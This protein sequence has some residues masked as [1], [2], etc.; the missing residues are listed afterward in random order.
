MLPRVY[1]DIAIATDKETG[2]QD[3]AV[4]ERVEL[5]LNVPVAPKTCYNFYCLCTGERGLGEVTG[6]PLCYRGTSFHRVV[7]G[8]CVQGGDLQGADGY[9]G[10]SIYGGEFDDE[11]FD[12]KHDAG[13]V[14]SMGKHSIY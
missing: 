2:E 8:M 10:E 9:G 6:V 7:A 13:G 11:N 3:P 14:L 5:E 4:V 1:L 12:L